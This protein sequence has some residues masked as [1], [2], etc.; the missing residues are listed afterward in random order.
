MQIAW[1]LIDCTMASK[2]NFLF[3]RICVHDK[4]E[5]CSIPTKLY[6]PA[7]KTSS[8]FSLR[9]RYHGV[10]DVNWAMIFCS[11]KCVLTHILFRRSMDYSI[12]ENQLVFMKTDKI[13]LYWFFSS[14]KIGR[15]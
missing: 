13:N 9:C 3:S 12:D 15:L 8:G 1:G 5:T 10:V 11:Y 7:S 6:N 2:S 4:V 14:L